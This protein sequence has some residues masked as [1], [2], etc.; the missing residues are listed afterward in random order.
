MRGKQK[1]KRDFHGSPKVGCMDI[2]C[3]EKVCLYMFRGVR[4]PAVPLRPLP[5]KGAYGDNRYYGPGEVKALSFIHL[6]GRGRIS[7][8]STTFY[9]YS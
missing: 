8:K 1:E 6:K 3:L 2:P 5:F 7:E 9:A 4:E